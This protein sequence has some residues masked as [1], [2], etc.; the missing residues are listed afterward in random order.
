MEFEL[1]FLI[2]SNQVFLVTG[3]WM[4]D[5]ISSTELLTTQESN[6]IEGRR[7]TS[8]SWTQVAPLPRKLFGLRG[9]NMDGVLYMT[10]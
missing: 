6:I 5:R 8:R 3:G 7:Q 10:G 4:T 2:I 1:Q 9:I